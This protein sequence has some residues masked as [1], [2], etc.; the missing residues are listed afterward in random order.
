MSITELPDSFFHQLRNT[1]CTKTNHQPDRRPGA[2][3]HREESEGHT[4]SLKCMDQGVPVY[5]IKCNICSH[6]GM[7]LVQ[8]D[9]IRKCSTS[10]MFRGMSKGF[11]EMNTTKQGLENAKQRSPGTELKE[12]H[13]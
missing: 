3:R 1:E 8:W 10:I 7:L 9:H 6:G 5:L 2:V 4:W 13:Y 12:Q 11:T